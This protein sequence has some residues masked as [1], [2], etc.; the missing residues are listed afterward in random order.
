MADTNEQI[1][2][3]RKV[4]QRDNKRLVGGYGTSEFSDTGTHTLNFSIVTSRD[5]AT[6]IEELYLS[7]DPETNIIATANEDV[8][9]N[10]DGVTLDTGVIITALDNQ[11]FV[12]IKLGAGKVH[13]N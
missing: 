7:S 3:L 12:K 13:C 5:D 8:P 6:E 4:T 11:H 2:N 1:S 10:I 9:Y